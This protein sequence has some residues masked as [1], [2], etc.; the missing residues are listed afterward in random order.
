M[1]EAA[2]GCAV[3][4]T[5][6]GGHDGNIGFYTHVNLCGYAKAVVSEALDGLY[7]DLSAVAVINSCD[8]M[9]RVGDLFATVAPNLP[10]HVIDIPRQSDDEAIDLFVVRLR[11]FAAFLERALCRRVDEDALGDCIDSSNQARALAARWEEEGRRGG[12]PKGLRFH[13]APL[14]QRHRQTSREFVRD[15]TGQLE[16]WKAQTPT[17][18]APRGR[19]RLLVTGGFSLLDEVFSALDQAG[20]DAWA[21]DHCHAGRM[22][23]RIE[24]TDDPFRDLAVAYLN[25]RP[26]PRMSFA[27]R[28]IDWLE[29]VVRDMRVDGILY[30]LLG[31]CDQFMY[32]VTLLRDRLRDSGTPLLVLQTSMPG[33]RNEQ[34]KTR[35][36][37]F[38][39]ILHA[40]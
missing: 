37:A 20:V 33:A 31:N 11:Q 24:R 28:R 39:E 8:A 34:W 26:C 25:R 32:D 15:M 22:T 2:G 10:S 30:V 12:F 7:S 35:L 21:V 4:L 14:T 40:R 9:R 29:E 36:D 19:P 6:A 1:I 38:C 18:A 16:A 27:D 13:Y 17:P 3:R 23:N 5:G